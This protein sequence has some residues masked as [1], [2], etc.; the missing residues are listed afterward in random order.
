M[1]T[2]TQQLDELKSL[3]KASIAQ[4]TNKNNVN[5]QI[6]LLMGMAFMLGQVHASDLGKVEQVSID[7]TVRK[8]NASM[9]DVNC[10]WC[11]NKFQA[12]SADV[13]RGW[14]MF[15]SKRC[16]AMEQEKRT[17]QYA[18]LRNRSEGY[19]FDEHGWDDHFAY[20]EGESD[21]Y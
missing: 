10:K 14:G 4:G 9:T 21:V 2:T 20:V 16:K 11:K 18:N 17:G 12:R 8:I 19:Y 6:D 3:L 13:K 1:A 7:K 15:C 5:N